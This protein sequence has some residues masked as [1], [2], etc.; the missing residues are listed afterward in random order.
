ML[1]VTIRLKDLL[2]L[3]FLKEIRQTNSIPTLMLTAMS[4]P[5]DRLD[6]LEYGA[7]DYMTKPFE[8]RELLLR[9]QNILKRKR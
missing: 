2:H 7:D 9:I 5:E 3:D 8:P 4:S 1:V 6:G